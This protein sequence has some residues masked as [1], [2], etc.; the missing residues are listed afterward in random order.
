MSKKLSVRAS[1]AMAEFVR[2]L[3]RESE[4]DYALPEMSTAL[5]GFCR[6]YGVE[7]NPEV[8]MGIAWEENLR[9]FCPHQSRNTGRC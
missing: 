9:N 4:T 2:A 8:V 3:I 6:S 5:S 7:V 1:V